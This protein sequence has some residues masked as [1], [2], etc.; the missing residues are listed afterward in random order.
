MCSI[1]FFPQCLKTHSSKTLSGLEQLGPAA[2]PPTQLTHY[3]TLYYS[4]YLCQGE[5]MEERDNKY[6]YDA[7][8]IAYQ[9]GN[10]KGEHVSNVGMK[11]N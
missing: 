11:E 7:F 8:F 5:S 10:I 6:F 4:L 1:G 2:S 9:L 3:A